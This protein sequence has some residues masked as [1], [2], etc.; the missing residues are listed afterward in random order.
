MDPSVVVLVLHW[1]SLEE[2][3][4]CLR[5]VEA[6]DYPNA[7]T[8]VVDNGST[9]GAVACIRAAYPDVRLIVNDRNLGYAQGNNV[10]LDRALKEGPDYILLL[11]NDV[12]LDVCC[13]THLV[14][15]GEYY[16]DAAFLGPKVYHREDPTRIQSAGAR[17]DWLWRSHQ[18]GLD[19]VD[20]GQFD[21]GEAVDYVVGAAILIRAS[22]LD[23]IGMLDPDFFLYREDV[24]W[25]LRARRLGYRTRYVPQ[26]QVWHRSHHVRE[27]ELPRTTYYMT[28]NSLMLVAKHKGG[29]TRL[30]TVL[31]RHLLMAFT[32]T[33][34]PKWHHKRQERNA[35]LKGIA[36]FVTR[37]VGQGY[38]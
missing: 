7:S 18:R 17:L 28:R 14:R 8:L 22:L 3:L 16:P 5:S 12:I 33:V 19:Q 38:A 35:L 23:R 20:V 25:C 15:A 34:R 6:L 36:D 31:F 10:G 13:L 9:G 29:T 32:W 11:N 26:A 30:L 21:V 1:N 24:D 2:T 27:H 37:K 4:A